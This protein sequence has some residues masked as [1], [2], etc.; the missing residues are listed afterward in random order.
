MMKGAILIGAT[1]YDMNIKVGNLYQITNGY[2]SDLP[3]DKVSPGGAWVFDLQNKG[4]YISEGTPVLIIE[5]MHS[6]Y[7][8]TSWKV[9]I[10]DNLFIVDQY[11][12]KNLL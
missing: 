7:R 3:D 1:H 12:L 2:F 11:Y 5:K 6:K 4:Y 9:L 10:G 8:D